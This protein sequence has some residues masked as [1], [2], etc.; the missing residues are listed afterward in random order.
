MGTNVIKDIT[1]EFE[2]LNESILKQDY[3]LSKK[4]YA[5]IK[6]K[7]LKIKNEETVEDLSNYLLTYYTEPKYR[8]K[9]QTLVTNLQIEHKLYFLLR[10][11]YE[12]KLVES[13]NLLSEIYLTVI[14]IVLLIIIYTYLMVVGAIKNAKQSR[15]IKEMKQ[16]KL[17]KIRK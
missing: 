16:E 5:I 13:T 17:E 7:I 6:K 1:P 14:E 10:L 3:E 4:I 12:S 8:L 11:I 9:F 2:K 15:K